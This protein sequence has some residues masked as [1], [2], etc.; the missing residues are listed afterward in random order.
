[1]AQVSISDSIPAAPDKVWEV[2]GDF[3]GMGRYVANVADSKM[4][5]E[6][7]GAVRSV[8][9]KDGSVIEEKLEKFDP[10]G[11]ELSYSII[12]APLPVKN[13]MSTMK[14]QAADGGSTL[15]WSSTF[16]ADGTTPEAKAEKLV[17]ITYNFGIKGIK[18]LFA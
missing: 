14:V 17:K 10:E 18:K 15:T 7:V 4:K 1:M 6:G 13:Y 5:G 12:Q 11:M 2:V 8:T 3:N 16:D 9:M